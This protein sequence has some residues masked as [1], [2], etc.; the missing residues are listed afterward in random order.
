LAQIIAALGASTVTLA[1]LVLVLM[2]VAHLSLRWWIGHKARQDDAAVAG[3]PTSDLRLRRWVTRGLREIL[4]ALAL[5]LWVH[6]L[7]FTLNLLIGQAGSRTLAESLPR[8]RAS[9]D[10]TAQTDDSDGAAEVAVADA[11]VADLPPSLRLEIH[12]TGVCWVYAVADG[13]RAVYRLMQPGERA[14]VEARLL[15]TL[16]VGDAGAVAFS[17]NGTTGRP[18]GRTGEAVT[19]RITNENLGSLSAEP[20]RA[21]SATDAATRLP[22]GSVGRA[23]GAAG[24][25][26]VT[27][28]MIRSS[29]QL[30]DGA[31]ADRVGLV[32]P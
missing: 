1:A 22:A 12:T 16:R 3:T 4:P 23:W 29:H 2:A 6:G 26:A 8:V 24:Q 21:T 13:K 31:P 15:I 5:L 32:S 7:S 10:A 9:V 19:V 25:R 18:L 17:I 14:R 30:R 28:L 27:A 11:A 20:P